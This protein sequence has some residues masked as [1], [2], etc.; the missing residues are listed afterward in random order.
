MQMIK[1]LIILLVFLLFISSYSVFAE[2]DTIGIIIEFKNKVSID[3]PN[4]KAITV[5]D[6]MKVFENDRIKTDKTGSATILYFDGSKKI[7]KSDQFF[8]IEKKK[9]EKSKSL[10]LKSYNF[11]NDCLTGCQ[12]ILTDVDNR[13]VGGIR[14][15]D[16]TDT[17]IVISPA[18]LKRLSDT[19]TVNPDKTNKIK[20]ELL[21]IDKEFPVNEN[22][23]INNLAKAN[24]LYNNNFYLDAEQYYLNVLKVNNSYSIHLILLEIYKATGNV[25]L[26]KNE[27]KILKLGENN[28]SQK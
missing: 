6:I 9:I 21:Q 26:L 12:N 4:T 8:T 11:L 27:N 24:L 20:D 3:R 15:P 10:I 25:E 28:E 14:G 2:S 18:S 23:V 17:N 7:I 19:E 22:F 16:E 13:E 1:Q 5:N